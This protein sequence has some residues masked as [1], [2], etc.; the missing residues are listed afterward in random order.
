MTRCNN[1]YIDILTWLIAFHVAVS[2]IFRH[3]PSPYISC[4]TRWKSCSRLLNAF[5]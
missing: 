2:W 3:K 4:A 1:A 5:T